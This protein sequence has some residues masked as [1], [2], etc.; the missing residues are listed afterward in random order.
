MSEKVP[1]PT[2]PSVAP[3]PPNSTTA[4]EGGRTLPAAPTQKR[5]IRATEPLAP[6]DERRENNFD[7]LRFVLASLVVLSH[8]YALS[9]SHTTFR[10][11]E[12]LYIA[13]RGQMDFGMF[14]VDLFFVISGF[15]ITHSWQRSK[16]LGDYLKKRILRI[17]PGFLVVVLLGTLI[18]GPLG[19]AD[20]HA[21]LQTLNLKAL[22]FAAQLVPPPLPATPILFVDQVFPNAINGSLWSI[23]YEF[24]CYLLVAGLGLL[25]L[26]RQRNMVL[27]LL[28]AVFAGYMVQLADKM[29]LIHLSRHLIEQEVRFIG[30]PGLYPRL[31]TYF[32][33]G[34]AFYLFRDRIP[35]SPWLLGVS[36]IALAGTALWGRGLEFA[37]PWCGTY[38]LFYI[39][40][41]RNLPLHHF[42]KY[43]DFSYGIYLY[44]FPIQQLLL[45]AAHGSLTPLVTFVLAFPLTCLCAALSWHLVEKPFLK[46]KR[47]SSPAEKTSPQS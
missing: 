1:A 45:H 28:L 9:L 32:L 31:V 37:F 4:L 38:V 18:V 13:T 23:R 41:S 8:S 29:K 25:Q 15:L 16:G 7:F 2:A 17:Y 34:M 19:A 36:L 44:A 20:V 22:Y 3:P 33:A 43:G 21:Y 12:P 5:A 27:A 40:F 14:A 47:A 35:R 42:A 11:R 46:K 10:L 26:F 30:A 39:A 6:I 24:W